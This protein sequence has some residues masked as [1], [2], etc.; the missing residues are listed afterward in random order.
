[1]ETGV[2]DLAPRD[3]NIQPEV[4]TFPDMK[5]SE[6]RVLEGLD[7]LGERLRAVRLRSRLSQ[8]KL[9]E[10]MGFNPTHGYKYI[11]RLEKGNVPNPTFRTVA[12]FLRC[13]GA[14]WEEVS[15]VLPK[16][17]GAPRPMARR[18]PA[19]S[20][21]AVRRAASPKGTVK[22][23]RHVEKSTEA[24]A[25]PAPGR[26]NGRPLRMRLRSDLVA[27]RARRA[28]SFWSRVDE[29]QTEVT[30]MLRA[31]KVLSSERHPYV[32]F[33]R[34]CCSTINAYS[35]ARRSMVERRLDELVAEEAS[36]GRDRVW[37]VRVKSLCIESLLAE[38][39]RSD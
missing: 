28:S 14:S 7:R 18:P 38:E 37:L 10:L 1:V 27:E 13:C 15:D 39:N 17:A 31:A 8:M 21:P 24:P 33:V 22:P 11:L 2:L 32:A 23:M 26:R 6:G 36:K 16:L 35:S 30:E 12:S 20:A 29:V 25:T 5:R 4:D 9:A 34:P 19:A 3:S